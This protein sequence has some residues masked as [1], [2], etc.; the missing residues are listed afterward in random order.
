MSL[1]LNKGDWTN[2]DRAY[3]AVRAAVEN[4]DFDSGWIATPANKIVK[5]NLGI[6]PK[7]VLVYAS[8]ERT[9]KIFSSDSFTSCTTSQ[10]TITGPKAYCRVLVDR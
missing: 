9:G 1:H 6:A 10:V 2:Q 5:H 7:T 3:S 4:Y 8:D